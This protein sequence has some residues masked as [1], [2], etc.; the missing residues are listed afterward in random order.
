VNAA[1][2]RITSARDLRQT[3]LGGKLIF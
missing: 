3:Q 2:G 1:F